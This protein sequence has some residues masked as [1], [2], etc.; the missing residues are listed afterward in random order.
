MKTHTFELPRGYKVYASDTSDTVHQVIVE[1]PSKDIFEQ[2]DHLLAGMAQESF[3]PEELAIRV[4]Q[5]LQILVAIWEHESP[6]RGSLDGVEYR[7]VLLRP[8]LAVTKSKSVMTVL[9][10]NL[11]LRAAALDS[12][13]G[14]IE[15]AAGISTE[16]LH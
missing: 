4:G 3:M 2:L 7:G 11:V 1:V 10:G 9:S 5:Y 8:G 12:L 14:T 16:D 6:K 15:E 13:A